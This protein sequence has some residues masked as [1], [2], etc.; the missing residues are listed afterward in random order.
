MTSRDTKDAQ[1]SGRERCLQLQ[2]SCSAPSGGFPARSGCR[3]CQGRGEV[4]PRE[5]L[6][7]SKMVQLLLLTAW[8]FLKANHGVTLCPRFH[9]LASAWPRETRHSHPEPGTQVHTDAHSHTTR[10]GLNGRPP[11]GHQRPGGGTN[12]VSTR[13]TVTGHTE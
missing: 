11:R 13:R 4:N 5:L 9:S 7:G 12:M 8:Q 6:M 3:R 1:W 10:R 2:Q